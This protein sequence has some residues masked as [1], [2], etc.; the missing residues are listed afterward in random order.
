MQLDKVFTNLFDD[1]FVEEEKLRKF[2]KLSQKSTM[3]FIP[4]SK[5]T[6]LELLLLF[7]VNFK[8][9]QMGSTIFHQT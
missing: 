5:C 9:L 4:T 2:A 7:F 1:I 3:V 8:V 6:G